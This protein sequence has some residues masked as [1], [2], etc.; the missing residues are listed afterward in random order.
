MVRIYLGRRVYGLAAV[1]FGIITLVWHDFN[2]WQQFGA[3][4]HIA[5]RQILVYIA[6]AIEIFGGVAIQWRR[7]ARAGALALGSIYLVFALLWAPR[8]AAEPRV[9]DRWGNFFEQFSLVSAA[10]IVYASFSPTDSERPTKAARIGYI[11]FGICVVSFTIE[12]LVY[13]SETAAFVPKWI[14]PG[15][16]FWAITTTIALGLAAAAILAG[17]SALLASK[18][19]T[20]MFIG[21][22]L[23]VWLPAPFDDPHKIINW[24]GNAQNLAITGAAW[25]VADF[26]SAKRPTSM[27]LEPTA[28]R[29]ISGLGYAR[30]RTAEKTDV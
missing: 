21:F 12:Q 18:L 19:L 14:P 28:E 8:I 17:R 26:L 15:Q 9:F 2:N 6:A 5:H 13:L 25:I 29:G 11:F 24:A 3:L 10:L 23:L 27:G 22:G 7:T 1:G 30:N 20:L 16:M 4:G